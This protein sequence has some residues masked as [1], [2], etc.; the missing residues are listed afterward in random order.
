[1]ERAEE[2]HGIGVVSLTSSFCYNG[3]NGV[4]LEE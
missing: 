1:M 2:F 3:S 4:M